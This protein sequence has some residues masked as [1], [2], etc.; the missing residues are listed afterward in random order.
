MDSGL[1]PSPWRFR[2]VIAIGLLLASC[3]RFFLS[4]GQLHGLTTETRASGKRR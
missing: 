1:R 3:W 4:S 2:L